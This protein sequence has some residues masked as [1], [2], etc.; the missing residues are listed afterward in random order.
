MSDYEWSKS[1]MSSLTNW[2][3]YSHYPSLATNVQRNETSYTRAQI[4]QFYSNLIFTNVVTRD[5]LS[6]NH[7][8]FLNKSKV[9][10]CQL[11]FDIFQVR[12]FA[13]F[14]TQ[15]RKPDNVVMPK[16]NT[17]WIQYIAQTF[18]SVL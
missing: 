2:R 9:H 7:V 12:P 18:V 13:D 14:N 1:R 10:I 11:P 17:T 4:V 3:I 5:T 16:A 6:T 8:L 15:I